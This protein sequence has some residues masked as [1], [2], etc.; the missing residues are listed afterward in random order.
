MSRCRITFKPLGSLNWVKGTESAGP[1]APRETEPARINAEMEIQRVIRTQSNARITSSSA[2]FEELVGG[3][4]DGDDRRVL[5]ASFDGN[6]EVP[7]AHGIQPSHDRHTKLAHH[8]LLEHGRRDEQARARLPERRQE[9]AVVELGDDARADALLLEE[10]IERPPQ[11]LADRRQQE[12][13]AVERSRKGLAPRRRELRGGEHGDRRFTERMAERLHLDRR[14]DRRIGDHQVERVRREIGE[15]ALGRAVAA[16]DL[17]RL[18]QPHR[19]LEQAIR[20]DLGDLIGDADLEAHRPPGRAILERVHQLAAE[21]ENVVGIAKD[22]AAHV[23]EDEVASRSL[24]QFF[25]ELIFEH[26]DLPAD[27]RLR[28]PELLARARDGA[29]ARDGPEVQKVVV[30][31][32]LH[33]AVNSAYS[34]T[35]PRIYFAFSIVTDKPLVAVIMGSTSD[36]DTM[37][38]AAEVLERFSVPFEKEVVSAHRTPVWMAEFAQGAEARGIQVIVAGAGG[39][40]HLPGM[41]ASHTV[42]PVLGVPVQSAALQ[43]LD[44]LLSIV[45]MPGGVPVGTLAIGKPGATNAG[46]AGRRHPGDDASRT[47]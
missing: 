2:A 12:R 44:S 46:P 5:E 40:A 13:R 9:R 33:K 31:E 42:L 27:R 7:L 26:A 47:S 45:Q 11:R 32:P 15:Q 8:F 16:D 3:F 29:L 6:R 18:R 23:G 43:G 10:V 20:D 35:V 41:V 4:G 22:D 1:C 39:A 14:R 34:A 19:R 25:A 17:H 21:A 36:W 37:C 28:E 24:K 38:H 30:V